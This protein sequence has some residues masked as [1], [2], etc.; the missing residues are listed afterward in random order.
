MLPW[1]LL[2]AFLKTGQVVAS[3]AWADT[4]PHAHTATSHRLT[5]LQTRYPHL[6]TPKHFEDRISASS[7]T[8]L[9]SQDKRYTQAFPTEIDVIMTSLPVLA[10]HLSKAHRGKGGGGI[11]PQAAITQLV[12]LIHHLATTQAEGVGFIWDITVKT[13]LP[14]P[15]LAALGPS[16]APN[17]PKCGSGAHRRTYIWQSLFPPQR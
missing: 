9:S 12:R 8:P 4:D 1:A 11:T 15:I 3:Y 16:T 5:R 17:A 2:E 7:W 10:R 14:H 13:L 6:H